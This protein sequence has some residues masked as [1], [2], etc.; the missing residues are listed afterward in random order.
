MTIKFSDQGIQFYDGSI[1]TSANTGVISEKYVRTTASGVYGIANDTGIKEPGLS[2][3]FTTTQMSS[4]NCIANFAPMYES[5]PATLYARFVLD[6][7][8]Y[9]S[10]IGIAYQLDR[11]KATGPHGMFTGFN[12]VSIGSH[13]IKIQVQNTAAGTTINLRAFGNNVDT[14]VV[15]YY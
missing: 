9:S 14:L 13:T 15:G 10:W 4:I 8:Q 7:S 12:N 6:N 5:G 3:S 2:V 11:N 1:L